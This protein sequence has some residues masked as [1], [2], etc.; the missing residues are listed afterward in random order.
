MII[1]VHIGHPADVHFFRHAVHAWQNHGHAVHITTRAIPLALHLLRTYGLQHEVISHRGRG[2]L[3]LGLEL[4]RVIC[5]LVPRFFRWKADVSISVGGTFTVHAARLAGVRGI[6]FYDTDTAVA[7]NRITYPF[8]HTIVTPDA[9]PHVLGQNHIRY[10]G[11]QE[12]AYLHPDHFT[13]DP[14]V[15]LRYG[16]YPDEPYTIVRFIAW[17]AAHDIGLRTATEKEKRRLVAAAGR[18]GR[19]VMVPESTDSREYHNLCLS[20]APE[21]FHH[22]LAFARCCVT[23]G[24][25]TASEACLLGTPTVYTNPLRPCYI[26]KLARYGILRMAGPGEDAPAALDALM[27]RFPEKTG[28]V[29][30][31]QSIVDE[32]INVAAFITDFVAG[33]IPAPAERSMNV[34]SPF[35]KAG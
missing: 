26:P 34:S 1:H 32:H 24:A 23:E 25:T 11:F 31:A 2:S 15:P 30:L 27:S 9:Y 3:G 33:R 6:M 22:L 21:D 13:P 18:Y 29:A 17:E 8:A 12:L 19:V 20:I 7:A 14:G 35:R 5:R 10:H 16:L 4:V 28:S